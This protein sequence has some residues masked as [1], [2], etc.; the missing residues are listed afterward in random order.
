MYQCIKVKGL[1][2]IHQTREVGNTKEQ[3]GGVQHN[4]YNV[5]LF[6]SMV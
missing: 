1:V 6:S 3:R 5:A 2:C 4:M